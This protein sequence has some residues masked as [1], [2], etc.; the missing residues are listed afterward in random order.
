MEK[1]DTCFVSNLSWTFGKNAEFG[2][3][4]RKT[5]T[6]EMLE[7]GSLDKFEMLIFVPNIFLCIRKDKPGHAIRRAQWRNSF[8]SRTHLKSRTWWYRIK[9]WRLNL[10]R[11][12]A[13][14]PVVIAAWREVGDA[15]SAPVLTWSVRTCWTLGTENPRLS[16]LHGLKM[17]MMGKSGCVHRW[18]SGQDDVRKGL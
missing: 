11:S 7:R 3:K 10:I 6:V 15:S 9:R 1:K 17:E 4:T 5:G 13:L 16:H 8:S 12:V 2:F 14:N 18:S